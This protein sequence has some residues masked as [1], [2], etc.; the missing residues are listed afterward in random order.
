MGEDGATCAEGL[1]GSAAVLI[2]LSTTHKIGLGAI[3]GAFI[4]FALACSFL[5][6]RWNPNF[7]GRRVGLFVV[8]TVL[9]ML[10]E[11]GAV[12]KF[13]AESKSEAAGPAETTTTT[14]STTTAPAPTGDAAAGKKVF[15]SAGCTACH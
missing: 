7:P 9:F 12:E 14:G 6:P 8:M 11:L 13:A 1:R 3:A 2:A 4:V 5:F 10:A 15:A